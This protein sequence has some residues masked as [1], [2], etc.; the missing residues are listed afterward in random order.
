[1]GWRERNRQTDRWFKKRY[2]SVFA[3]EKPGEKEKLKTGL[4]AYGW[5]RVSEEM[6]G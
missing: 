2:L 3:E 4:R 1:M 6:V 5:G